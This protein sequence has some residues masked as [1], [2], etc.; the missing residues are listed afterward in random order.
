MTAGRWGQGQQRAPLGKVGGGGPAG[1]LYVVEAVDDLPRTLRSW[2]SK[3]G[4]SLSCLK[5]RLSR[6]WT[7]SRAILT[8]PRRWGRGTREEHARHAAWLWKLTQLRLMSERSS[9]QKKR[10]RARDTHERSP[11]AMKGAAAASARERA[12]S[13]SWASVVKSHSLGYVSRRGRKR[14]QPS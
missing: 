9:V 6:G 10:R 11:L 7:V 14:R 13:T 3:T 2:A 12:L 1:R 8:P 5:G 4:L